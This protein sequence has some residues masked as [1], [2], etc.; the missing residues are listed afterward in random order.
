M[1][2]WSGIALVIL[3]GGILATSV[4]ALPS[5]APPVPTPATPSAM[6]SE[7]FVGNYL[8][9]D[10]ALRSNDL[11]TAAAIFQKTL[12]E[13]PTDTLALRN[14]YRVSLAQGN[15]DSA[16]S[17]IRRYLDIGKADSSMNLVLAAEAMK[18]KESGKAEIIL[19]TQTQETSLISGSVNRVVTP[20]LQIWTKA[21][22][23]KTD[24]AITFVTDM[25]KQEEAPDLFMHYQ[26][27]LLYELTG[28]AQEAEPHLSKIIDKE[29]ALP[30]HFVRAAGNIFER[31]HQPQRALEL[32]TKFGSQYPQSFYFNEA[33]ERAKA[34]T[35]VP[36]SVIPAPEMGFSEVLM[37]AARVLYGSGHYTEGML[38]LQLALYLNP[39]NDEAKMLLATYYEN[40]EN[41]QKT[42]EVYK[43]IPH[44]SD[45]YLLSRIA[46]ADNLYQ[47]GKADKAIDQLVTLTR[48]ENAPH[49]AL[50]SL[51]DILRKDKRYEEAANIYGR[52]IGRL[53][54]PEMKDWPVFFARGI[55]YER[56][57][58]WPAAEADLKKALELKPGQPEVLNYLGYSWIDRNENIDE[59]KAMVEKAV[60]ARPD[61]AQ[62]ID[63]MGW[64]LFKT[65]DY[66]RASEFL[67]K[68]VEITPYDAVIN[69]HLGDAYWRQ[70]RRTEAQF[71]WRRVLQYHGGNEDVSKAAV[72]K[73]LQHGLPESEG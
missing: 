3:L 29:P 62:I 6:V 35:S 38:Y 53:Q 41:R 17:L 70:G 16:V 34:G 33:I 63:S 45:F 61:D 11:D 21:G 5:E 58:N 42:I 47:S 55:C 59:A 67:E 65:K 52:I 13:N 28:K 50:I 39:T 49:I 43:T 22:Q 68:A 4:F 24:E 10:Y 51:A 31:I 48:P 18:N 54:T 32:Y 30:Y 56:A 46:I 7:Y 9:G 37:E 8:S 2:R 73:K 36:D 60:T 57:K 14:A 1:N 19:N 69:D 23:K 66:E 25:M 12:E 40:L 71:Q 44:G 64:V 15:V 27:A 26:T 72:E 20:F